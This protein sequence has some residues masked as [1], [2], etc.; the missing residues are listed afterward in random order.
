MNKQPEMPDTIWIALEATCSGMWAEKEKGFISSGY[1]RAGPFICKGI[2]TP[3]AITVAL[4][5]VLEIQMYRGT[6]DY[7]HETLGQFIWGQGEEPGQIYETIVSLL[8][9]HGGE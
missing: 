1:T 8:R 4:D 3:E 6:S 2:V 5:A 9:A 7:S